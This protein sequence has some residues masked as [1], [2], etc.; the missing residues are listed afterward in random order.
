MSTSNR[1]GPKVESGS[2]RLGD[3]VQGGV[4]EDREK[5]NPKHQHQKRV[6]PVDWVLQCVSRRG[7]YCCGADE[8]YQVFPILG[9]G[10][11]V[12]VGLSSH[13][14]QCVCQA[15]RL[16]PVEACS[17]RR[18]KRFEGECFHLPR[19]QCCGVPAN[20]CRNGFVMPESFVGE[21]ERSN[22]RLSRVID[23]FSI[24]AI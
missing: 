22:L 11:A 17:R 20:S 4:V 7:A 16:Q 23:I 14:R 6:V 2:D 3:T 1:E 18:N 5:E 13:Y 19:D 24:S 8:S 12:P 15:Q 9:S 10:V 21:T